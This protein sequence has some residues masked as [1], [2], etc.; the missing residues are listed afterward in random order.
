[1][2]GR[3]ARRAP[4]ALALLGLLGCTDSADPEPVDPRTE[5]LALRSIADAMPP[6]ARVLR[7][8]TVANSG[9]ENG[10]EPD[11]SVRALVVGFSSGTTSG[12]ALEL[13]AD[14]VAV[15]LPLATNELAVNQIAV[16]L[17]VTGHVTAQLVL[18]GPD[19]DGPRTI[20]QRA[21]GRGERV[22]LLFD[23]PCFGWPEG[24]AQR[25]TL[26]LSGERTKKQLVSVA[27]IHRPL[28]RWLPIAREGA[29]MVEI[30]ESDGRVA[31]GLTASR[32][33]ETTLEADA[34][35]RLT[36]SHCVPP[37]SRGPGREHALVVT[38]RDERGEQRRETLA[39][40]YEWGTDSL[41]L[42]PFSGVVTARFE[43]NLAGGTSG[44]VALGEPTLERVASHAPT[45][46][47]ITSDTH[48]AD[49][50]GALSGGAVRTPALDRLAA[51]GVL[52]EDCVSSA[53]VTLPSHVTL[54]TGTP[55]R[56]TGVVYN[57]DVLGDG[58]RTLAEQF[59]EAGWVTYAAVSAASLRHG[60]SGLGQGFDRMAGPANGF[61]DASEGI[62]RVLGWIEDAEGLPLFVWLHLFDAHTPYREQPSIEHYYPPDRDPR[63]PALPELAAWK[64][65]HAPA[66][67]RDL[68]YVIGL[69][70]SEIT[71]LD[72][73]L[74]RLFDHARVERAI[75]AFTADHGES[76][77][78]HDIYFGH[79]ELYP[80]TLA[81]PLI[82]TFPGAP[83]GQRATWPVQQLDLGRTLLQLA[84]LESADFPGVT[85]PVLG[86][87]EQALPRF[88]LAAGGQS[89]S[90][91]AGDAFFVLHL[92]DHDHIDPNHPGYP[93]HSVELYDRAADPE[94]LRELSAE[95]PELAA[96]LRELVIDWLLDA[97]TMGWNVTGKSADAD[98]LDE[99]AELGYT[100]DYRESAEI[101][102]FD[103]DCECTQCRTFD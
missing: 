65:T 18:G 48:R 83:E 71:H 27:L 66:D 72:A 97:R 78:E 43:L 29:R 36:F 53:N 75:V 26:T 5:R 20:R 70:R 23:V 91:F 3:H 16:T 88:A 4:A 45:V 40:S 21:Q 96:R 52:F 24:L 47:L 90:V 10:W 59:H 8:F 60:R 30:L 98:A 41:S 51:R 102:W 80:Q 64:T 15:Q 73:Q 19:E 62:E 81:V 69:Y 12:E 1:M 17:I 103:P 32:P 56:D 13:R 76:L 94:C 6:P 67:A 89:A 37:I 46:V 42:E 58:P 14:E 9:G 28:E 31:V 84:G 86:A 38:L 7:E 49:H 2:R 35:Q 50:L 63:D 93:A 11:P 33:L 92:T 85:I 57:A 87:G 100:T 34:G 82:L 99:L 22:T 39:S 55:P 74:A 54:M 61:A 44:L 95:R 101:L 77:T 68:D 79:Q 25:M